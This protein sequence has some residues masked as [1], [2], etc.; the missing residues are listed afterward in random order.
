MKWHTFDAQ[1]HR[2]NGVALVTAAVALC[3]TVYL[4]RA[5]DTLRRRGELI[6]DAL[7]THLAPIGWQHI[8]LTGPCPPVD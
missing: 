8:N 2:A 5:L 3:N 4:G 1:Q 7:L 6:P